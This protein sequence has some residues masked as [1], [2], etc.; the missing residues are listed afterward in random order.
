MALQQW[1]TF[2][3]AAPKR[4]RERERTFNKVPHSSY[5]L[6]TKALPQH[7]GIIVWRNIEFDFALLQH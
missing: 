2:R 4:A 5:S 7:G 6:N 1:D 3:L